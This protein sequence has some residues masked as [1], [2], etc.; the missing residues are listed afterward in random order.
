MKVK[1]ISEIY[2]AVQYQPG[3]EDGFLTRYHDRQRPS[4]SSGL[5]LKSDDIPITSPHIDGNII[6]KDDIILSTDNIKF[7]V[8]KND[9]KAR[10]EEVGKT[11]DGFHTFNEL[12][13]HRMILF[14][15]IC[16]QN[17]DK[18]WK[19]RLHSDGTMFP[20]YFIV[21]IT[22]PLGDYTYHYHKDHWDKFNVAELD[23]APV[24]DGHKPEDVDRLLSLIL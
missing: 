14:S 10:F 4:A 24:W 2:D 8:H 16:S 11:S 18:A 3:M 7:R 21:G 17:K 9:F 19:S 23:K 5:P 1:K 6:D 12:Y 15:V 22:T 20:D 13:H